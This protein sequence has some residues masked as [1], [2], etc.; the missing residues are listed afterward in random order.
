MGAE[1]PPLRR[2]GNDQGKT[3]LHDGKDFFRG[4]IHDLQRAFKYAGNKRDDRVFSQF[5]ATACDDFR[6]M[7]YIFQSFHSGQAGLDVLGYV[8]QA[9]KKL[10]NVVVILG[11]LRILNIQG[12]DKEIKVLQSFAQLGSTA[13]QGCITPYF[14]EHGNLDLYL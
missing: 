12:P 1:D 4:V 3:A 8:V 6:H 14:P 11:D 9:C 13:K 2:G 5:F 10:V 7:Y